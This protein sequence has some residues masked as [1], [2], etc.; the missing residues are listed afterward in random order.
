MWYR[1]LTSLALALAFLPWR[2]FPL[3]RTNRFSKTATSRRWPPIELAIR[4]SPPPS[5]RH[6]IPRKIRTSMCFRVERA[7]HPVEHD[8]PADRRPGELFPRYGSD[9]AG[10]PAGKLPA[11]VVAARAAGI[12]L[13]PDGRI[14]RRRFLSRSVARPTGTAG[15]AR[16][17]SGHRR[18]HG[19]RLTSAGP[20][21]ALHVGDRRPGAP[22]RRPIVQAQVASLLDPCDDRQ[23]GELKGIG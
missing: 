8:D 12:K 13:L 23:K 3:L 6:W 2:R 4:R 21:G 7:A 22:R 20:T 14:R 19:G 5:T 18:L 10:L 16:D 9:R 17:A 1:R 11:G 15:R